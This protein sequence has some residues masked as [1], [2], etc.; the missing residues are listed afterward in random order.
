MV[1]HFAG[2]DLA[3]FPGVAWNYEAVPRELDRSLLDF[4]LTINREISLRSSS[5]SVAPSPPPKL[6]PEWQDALNNVLLCEN[7]VAHYSTRTPD[8][9]LVGDLDDMRVFEAQCIHQK[10]PEFQNRLF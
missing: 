5:L 10:P 6:R 2:F 3:T 8:L 7:I 4:R 1:L 9:G